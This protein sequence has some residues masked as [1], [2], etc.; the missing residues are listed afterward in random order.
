VCCQGDLDGLVI[1]RGG[2]LFQL[3][4]L[5]HADPLFVKLKHSTILLHSPKV[6]NQALQ[7]DGVSHCECECAARVCSKCCV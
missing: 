6:Y 4:L 3:M 5:A 7:C 2:Q 1:V